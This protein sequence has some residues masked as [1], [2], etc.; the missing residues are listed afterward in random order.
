MIDLKMVIEN[1]P[2]CLKNSSNLR[3]LLK[4]LYPE[5]EYR[6]RIFIISVILDSNVLRTI[7][8]SVEITET[9]IYKLAKSLVN[10]YGFSEDL[11]IECLE[12]WS[13]SLGKY[14]G[15]TI[16]VNK[17][18]KNT[19]K[20]TKIIKQLKNN[21]FTI[22]DGCLTKYTGKSVCK[23]TIPEGVTS[24]GAKAFSR[25]EV[26]YVYLPSTCMSIEDSAFEK[27]EVAEIVLPDGL[28]NIGSEAF[29]YCEK[30]RK[31]VLPPK[32]K[33]IYRNTFNECEALSNVELNE[34]L[35]SIG[36]M[37][38]CDCRSL[39]SVEV[40]KSVKSISSSAFFQCDCFFT[41]IGE[42]GSYAEKYASAQ[43]LAFESNDNLSKIKVGD[44]LDG[45]ITRIKKFGAFV[46]L[47]GGTT[48]LIHISE[49]SSTYVD[50]ISK[51]LQIGQI[52][53]VKVLTVQNNKIA[54][55]IKQV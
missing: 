7:K 48:G 16:K 19:S 18:K 25:A 33:S 3:A 42:K 21:M 8:T 40:P 43:R 31:I 52:V 11:C 23:V 54:L 51:F 1:Y 30:L 32:I 5:L 26:Q 53:K 36:K 6:S 38:F 39:V 13:T 4:D 28:E 47:P 9:D 29:A 55:S 10:E 2:Y 20:P 45:R 35:T 17:I 34:G 50:D 27:S 24:I 44:V 49:I 46:E 37:A 41:I 12:L 14:K 22:K 15:Q